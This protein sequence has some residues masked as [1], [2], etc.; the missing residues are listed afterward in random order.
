VKGK[1][2]CLTLFSLL[3]IFSFTIDNG[4]AYTVASYPNEVKVQLRNNSTTNIQ[5]QGVFELVDRN[6]NAK[7]LL[8]PGV[9]ITAST[10]GSFTLIKVGDVTY[11]SPTGYFLKETS[12]INKIAKFTSN[13]SIRR[14][15][16][17]N[18]EIRKTM[19]KVEV[20]EYNGLEHISNGVKWFH[21][22]AA[23]GT[24][25][26]VSS[27][28]TI[29]EDAPKNLSLF[30]I[31]NTGKSYRGSLQIEASGS[32]AK[33]VNVLDMENY[34]KGVLPNEMP[35]LWHPEAVKAQAIVSRTYATKNRNNL[36][37]TTASQVYNGYGTEHPASNKAIEETS[38]LLVKYNGKPIEAYFFSTSGGRTANVGDV[39]NSNQ[40]AYPYL[41]SVED[42]YEES[43]RANWKEFFR[44]STILKSFG[45]TGASAIL[46]DIN[47]LATG[48]NGEVSSITLQT[49]SG[50]ITKSGNENQIRKLLPQGVYSGMLNSNWFTISGTKEYSIQNLSTV[51]NQYNINGQKVMLGNG[52]SVA[53]NNNEV[54]I[55]MANSTITKE[56]DPASIIVEGRGFGHRI[57]MSQHGANGLAKSGKSAIEI[58]QHYYKGTTVEK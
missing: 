39:W 48:A 49:S 27:Q 25:G 52:Q 31:T 7:T 17:T 28:T 42:P 46:Y 37:N 50:L 56:T 10:T 6:T 45:V 13:T 5:L 4:K 36:V 33:V 19:S 30:K 8:V 57:G 38:G 35:A 9:N 22:T 41:V 23:D 53:L 24:N 51:T 16:T 3:L 18:A 12:D 2:F 44:A 32:N 14:S 29:I 54:Q 40:A 15:A 43:P 34:L 1:I 47:A 11:K 55:Q 21:V 20:A 58:I 26:W